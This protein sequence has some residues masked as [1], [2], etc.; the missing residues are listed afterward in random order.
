M[1][2][3]QTRDFGLTLWMLAFYIWRLVL[4]D[5]FENSSFVEGIEKK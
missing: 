5:L 2:C 3:Q 1:G 4:A